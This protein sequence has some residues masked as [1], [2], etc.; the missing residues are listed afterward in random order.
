MYK[1][2]LGL[3]LDRLGKEKKDDHVPTTTSPTCINAKDGAT[4]HGN[5][6]A[7]MGNTCQ[8]YLCGGC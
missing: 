6:D 5:Y 8:T 2:G 7:A 4:L 3:E 1:G